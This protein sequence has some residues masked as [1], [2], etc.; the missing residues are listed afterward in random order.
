M[1]KITRRDFLKL[2]SVV[3]GGAAISALLPRTFPSAQATGGKPNVII[4]LFDTMTA[5]HLSLYGYPR[6]TTPN[7]ERFAQKATVYNS[8]YS[9][10]SYTISGTASIL[11]GLYPWHHRAI[12]P[13]GPVRRELTGNNL[14][15]AVGP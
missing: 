4:L 14:F 8:H 5:P 7:L 13:S 11:T 6:K 2:A 3:T 9:G 15:R 1:S 10:G 12:N